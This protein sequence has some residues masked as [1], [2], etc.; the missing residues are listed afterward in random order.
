[1]TDL[2]TLQRSARIVEDEQGEPVVQIPLQIWQ[3]Y[4]AET[5]STQSQKAQVM[6]LLHKWEHEP[7]D[8]MPNEWWEDFSDFLASQRVK[9]AERDF[10]PGDE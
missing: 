4:L 5:P 7:E 9:F 3:Q 10:T 8:D 2:D 1:M 6:A